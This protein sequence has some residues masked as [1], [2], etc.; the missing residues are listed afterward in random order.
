MVFLPVI[1][2]IIAAYYA[3]RYSPE[4]AFLDVYIPVLLLLP[5]YYRWVIPALPD[6]TFEQAAILPIAAAWFAR[7]TRRWKYSSIDVL[8]CGFA[9]CIGYSEFRNAGYKEAQNLM[10]DMVA[11]VL[12]PYFLTKGIVEPNGLRVAFARKLV[13]L[14]FGLSLFSCYEFRMGISPW[15]YMDPLF[16][17]QGREWFTTFRY[18]F[19]RVAGPFGHPILAGLALVIGFRIQ[20]WLEWSGHWEPN[21]KSFSM[22]GVSKARLI[23]IG[24]IAGM[25]MTMCRGPW[26]GGVVGALF[27]AIGRTRNRKRAALMVAGCI[28]FIGIPAATALYNYAAV[29]RAKAKTAEQ[30]TAA[31]R[32]ELLD[33]YVSV[34]LKNVV[35]GYGR[36]TWP[37]IPTAP[38]IDNYYLLLTLMHGL[39]AVAFL[40]TIMLVMVVKLFRFEMARPPGE[41]RG[42]SLGF[43]L[44]GI[45][46]AIA[47]TIGTVYLGLQAVPLFAIVTG[48]SDGYL[49][50]GVGAGSVSQNTPIQ[51]PS[52]RPFAFRRI[53]A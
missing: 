42:S 23:T 9:L 18:G 12:L 40:V 33:K 10:F 46:I 44:A 24:L 2:L 48:W 32:K 52:A 21:F 22:P 15:K 27:T 4:K 20:R 49:C 19:A 39:V 53:V 17:G 28:V 13:I 3:F 37:K 11:S 14:L 8:M 43:T 6:P 16:P 34:A 29:G 7:N 5:M 31:Y 45:Y 25:G 47:V 41:P 38:S 50:S 26:L 35:W 30:E 36:N 1:A 51:M